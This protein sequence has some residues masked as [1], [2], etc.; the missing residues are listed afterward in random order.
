MSESPR[1]P[2]FN[3]PRP[4]PGHEVLKKDVGVWDAAVEI[5]LGPG[6]PPQLSK[7]VA[8]NRLACG[9]LWLVSDFKNETTGFEGH[10]VYGFDPRKDRY[11]GTWVDPMRTFL[12]VG[13]GT[14]DPA[15]RTMTMWFETTGPQ[16]K[17]MRWRETTETRDGD[18]QVFRSFLPGPDGAEH[19]VM[20][21]TYVRRRG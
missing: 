14:F 19:E 21:V 12:A 8:H 16:G 9:G 7:G 1:P 2:E 17:P 11:V 15:S 3:P 18:T 10:G 5:R 13:E 20:T 6:V 4:G